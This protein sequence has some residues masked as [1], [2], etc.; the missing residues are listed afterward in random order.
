MSVKFHSGPNGPGQCTASSKPCPFGGESGT[1][2][3]YGTMEEAAAAFESTMEEKYGLNVTVER[4]EGGFG[5]DKGT[6]LFGWDGSNSPYG[7]GV[8]AKVSKVSDDGAGVSVDLDFYDV[9]HT[10]TDAV[11]SQAIVRLNEK[12]FDGDNVSFNIVSKHGWENSDAVYDPEWDDDEDFP[13]V[14]FPLEAG[15]NSLY[16]EAVKKDGRWVSGINAESY[17]FSD[18]ED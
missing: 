4:P 8:S 14:D 7:H 17:G 3:H 5:F 13:S 2:N 11:I 16:G 9:T 6:E 18:P 1:D 12:G 15:Q 10:D